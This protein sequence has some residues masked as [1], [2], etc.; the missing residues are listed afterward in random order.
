MKKKKKKINNLI[1]EINM[2]ES[3]FEEDKQ[4]VNYEKNQVILL[5]II[6]IVAFMI[7]LLTS[8]TTLLIYITK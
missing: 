1:P 8:V 3:D 2:S 6:G 4:W 5:K 7:F